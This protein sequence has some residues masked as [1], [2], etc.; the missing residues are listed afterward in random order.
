MIGIG[1]STAV[2]L[3]L[4]VLGA[5][6][7]VPHAPAAEDAAAKAF[8]P[9]AADQG[10]LYLYRESAFAGPVLITASVGQRQL[11]QLAPDTYFRVDLPPGAYN[12]R[13]NTSEVARVLSVQLDPGQIRF[14]EIAARHGIN[15]AR[16]AIFEVEAGK[17]RS[18]IMAGQRALEIR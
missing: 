3:A 16:C 17:G 13:C 8:G 7:S 4:A 1:R 2:G 6:G 9:P 11:G 15:D 12:L 14:V 10:A 18:A 5:C